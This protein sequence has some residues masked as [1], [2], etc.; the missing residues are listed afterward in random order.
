[1]NT[2]LIA[3]S[4]KYKIVE[5]EAYSKSKAL[6]FFVE[7]N[8]D[9]ADDEDLMIKQVCKLETLKTKQYTAHIHLN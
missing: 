2:Y 7:M 3:Y 6:D 1:M 4:E 5:I 9:E 8:W